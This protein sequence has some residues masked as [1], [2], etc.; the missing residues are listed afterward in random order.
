MTLFAS[1]RPSSDRDD[2][3][4]FRSEIGDIQRSDWR[5][6]D[7]R[8]PRFDNDQYAL[9]GIPGLHRGRGDNLILVDGD[10]LVVLD[11]HRCRSRS[12]RF[13]G[14]GGASWPRG[15]RGRP[16]FGHRKVQVM[17]SSPMFVQF[18]LGHSRKRAIRMWTWKLALSIVIAG[19]VLLQ[20]GLS[21]RGV[22]TVEPSALK[23]P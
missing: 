21:V 16:G 6:R 10:Q 23:R 13:R 11:R 14:D 1:W 2:L 18:L 15:G 17:L 19:D 12:R 22:G 20:V 7:G 9:P 4:R 8:H 5:Q 3:L